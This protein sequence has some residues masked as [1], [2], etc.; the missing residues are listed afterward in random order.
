MSEEEKVRSIKG[1]IFFV[2]LP[3]SLPDNFKP[4][5][6]DFDTSCPVCNKPVIFRIVFFLDSLYQ[7]YIRDITHN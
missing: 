4:K 1:M 2:D 6:S 3:N 7:R 5:I